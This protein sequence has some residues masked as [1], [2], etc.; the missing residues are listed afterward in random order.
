V[1]AEEE[2]TRWVLVGPCRIFFPSL[3]VV[4]PLGLGVCLNRGKRMDGRTNRVAV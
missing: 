1:E 4:L 3:A 2:R